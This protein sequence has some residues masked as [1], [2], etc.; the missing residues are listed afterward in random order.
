MSW[1]EDDDEIVL[2]SGNKVKLGSVE[3]DTTADFMKA[4]EEGGFE[5]KLVNT[6]TGEIKDHNQVIDAL[7]VQPNATPVEADDEGMEA[8][9]W[10]TTD[11]NTSSKRDVSD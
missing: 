3:V 10:V 8:F 7:Y 5:K 6:E 2:P 9:Q 11:G 1:F 4:L